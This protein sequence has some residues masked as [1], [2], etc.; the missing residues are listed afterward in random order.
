LFQDGD[1]GVGVF[2]KRE[3]ILIGRFCLG[4]VALQ[5]VGVGKSTVSQSS[6]RFVAHNAAMVED[7]LELGGGF[8]ALMSGQVGVSADV[9]TG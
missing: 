3:E 8:A 6:D 4:G 5:G 1:V 7:F 9:E 2:P